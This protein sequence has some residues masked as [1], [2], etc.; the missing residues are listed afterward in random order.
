MTDNITG[1]EQDTQQWRT[2][3]IYFAFIYFLV[4]Y[5]IQSAIA[6]NKTGFHLFYA[7]F[8][9]ELQEYVS[10]AFKLTWQILKR[11]IHKILREIEKEKRYR[12]AEYV[13]RRVCFVN[14]QSSLHLNVVFSLYARMGFATCIIFIMWTSISGLEAWYHF[15]FNISCGVA[16]T[17]R[18]HQEK[19]QV[20][21]TRGGGQNIFF[22]GG[23]IF[24][25]TFIF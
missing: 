25:V 1:Q 16:V 8:E 21:F 22:E 20:I 3:E 18:S 2:S 6:G 23:W 10:T 14:V 12:K 19:F 9:T 5:S 15:R 24:K 7:I 4:I 17:M 11:G 13:Q